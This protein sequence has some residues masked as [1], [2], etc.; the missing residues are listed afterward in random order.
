[1]LHGVLQAGPLSLRKHTDGKVYEMPEE[2]GG[3]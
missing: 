2:H 3:N 1:M